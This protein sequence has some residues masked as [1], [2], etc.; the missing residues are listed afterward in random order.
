[1]V[2]WPWSRKHGA[3]PANART[4]LLLF[5]EPETWQESS[6]SIFLQNQCT[7]RPGHPLT[8]WGLQQRP[9]S[10][11]PAKIYIKLWGKLHALP[12]D[13]CSASPSSWNTL[14][15]TTRILRLL[16][17]LNT[18]LSGT[19]S[20]YLLPPLR[21]LR[22]ESREQK[23]PSSIFKEEMNFWKLLQALSTTIF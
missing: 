11:N 18:G 10:S 8:S 16:S 7:Q 12:T 1:M 4:N 17:S 14:R 5:C 15:G 6:P 2:L 21:R 9:Q 22:T 20:P 3:G 23:S 19:A 13:I